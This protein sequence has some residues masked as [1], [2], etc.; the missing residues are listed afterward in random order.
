MEVETV[1]SDVVSSTVKVCTFSGPSPLITQVG[2]P[3]HLSWYLAVEGE[4]AAPN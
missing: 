3:A 1:V 2:G 4:L